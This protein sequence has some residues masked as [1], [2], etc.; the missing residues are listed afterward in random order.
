ML[1]AINIRVG[2][3]K[4]LIPDLAVVP[5]PGLDLTVCE[6]ADVVPTRPAS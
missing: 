4:I 3:G 1:E 5:T 6:A 2:P